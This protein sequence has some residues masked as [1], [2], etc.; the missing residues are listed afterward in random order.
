MLQ[1]KFIPV[2]VQICNSEMWLCNVYKILDWIPKSNLDFMWLAHQ[3]GCKLYR[4]TNMVEIDKCRIK[5]KTFVE[6]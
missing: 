1:F 6:I 4:W 3:A 5:D 2:V